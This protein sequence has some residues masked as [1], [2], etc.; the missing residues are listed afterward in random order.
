MRASRYGPHITHLFYADDY[1]FFV[2]SSVS[3]VTRVKEIPEA[4]ALSYGQLVNYEKS[5]VYFSPYTPQASR[6]RILDNL[7][8]QEVQ[9]PGHYSGCC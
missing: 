5:L 3:E 2:K 1:L 4:Y 7:D 6:S 8:I 9:D